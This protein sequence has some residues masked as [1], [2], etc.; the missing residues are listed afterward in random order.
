MAR[1]D[2][3][4]LE[5]EFIKAVLPNTTRGKKRVDER[6]LPPKFRTIQ[7]EGLFS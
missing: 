4:N 1:L 6:D 5:W 3:S 2:V 7:N